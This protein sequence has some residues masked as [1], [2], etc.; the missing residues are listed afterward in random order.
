MSERD[1]L[2]EELLGARIQQPGKV[3]IE[4][5]DGTRMGDW[6]DGAQAQDLVDGLRAERDQLRQQVEKLLG[7]TDA[8]LGETRKAGD[9][10]TG[11]SYLPDNDRVRERIRALSV[12]ADQVRK[13]LEG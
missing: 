6:M 5:D 7:S 10:P 9:R 2:R 1:H 8:L 4:R 11:S 13:E 12:A 3:Y